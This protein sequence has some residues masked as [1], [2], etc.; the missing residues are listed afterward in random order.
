MPENSNYSLPQLIT[1]IAALITALVGVAT[2][3]VALLN[4]YEAARTARQA[5]QSASKANVE[6]NQLERASQPQSK[7]PSSTPEFVVQLATYLPQNCNVAQ[8]EIDSYRSEFAASPTLWRVPGGRAIVVGIKA[9]S[10]EQAAQL[11][12][13]AIQMASNPRFASNDLG[14]ARVRTNPGWEALRSCSDL[15]A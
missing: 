5:G 4:S 11:R 14:N 6:L 12:A 7:S 9:V 8:E 15:R 3:G 10:A 1:A 13:K 2:G